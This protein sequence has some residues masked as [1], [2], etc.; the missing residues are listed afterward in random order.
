[1]HFQACCELPLFCWLSYYWQEA[2][3]SMKFAV[4]IR[5]VTTTT[6]R[7]GTASHPKGTHVS[8]YWTPFPHHGPRAMTHLLSVIII[9]FWNV[10]K[11][12]SYIIFY[13][14]FFRVAQCFEDAFILLNVP[15]ARSPWWLR[16]TPLYAHAITGLSIH[17]LL[18]I[19]AASRFGLLW[20]ISQTLNFDLI[21]STAHH[22]DDLANLSLKHIKVEKGK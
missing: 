22:T 5:S 3:T 20:I 8:L 12:G 13:A 7:H 21:F 18:D 6:P 15:T 17:H 9:F 19:W 14:C 11:L 16:S 1:M 4:C 10:I 2:Y